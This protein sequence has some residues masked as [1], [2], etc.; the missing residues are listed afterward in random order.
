METP[1]KIFRDIHLRIFISR[2]FRWVCYTALAIVVASGIATTFATFFQCLPIEFFWNKNIPGTCID[3]PK[4]WLA[5]AVLNIST[6]VLVLAL[7]I[8]EV[9]KLQLKLKEKIMLCSVFLLGGL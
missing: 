5:N 7:P 4:F 8:R 6:D 9:F 1:P 3:S 2:N